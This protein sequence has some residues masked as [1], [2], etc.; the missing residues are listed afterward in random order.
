M[1][2]V[3]LLAVLLFGL[4][5]PA[6]AGPPY[7]TDDPEPTD[8]GHFEI[9]LYTGQTVELGGAAGET[10]LD[11]NYGALPDLQL[12]AV[13]PL[14]YNSPPHGETVRGLGNVELEA[15][16]RF[17][18]QETDGWDVA[19]F[20]QVVL[21]SPSHRVADGHAAY[22]LPVWAEKDFGKWSTFGG[23]GCG[24]HRGG[25]AI[26]Y[27]LVGWALTREIYP[28]LRLGAEIYHQTADVQNSKPVTGLSGGISYDLSA[29]YHLMLSAGP[30]LDNAADTDRSQWY[31][32]L[33]F[34]F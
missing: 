2:R 33:E 10:G 8:T 9:Y 26:D 22:F 21:P 17:L 5:S 19:M 14:S 16:Y 15:K 34:T 18:H 25:G 1:R 27:C 4:A 12:T 29:H 31:A 20:P 13:V 28:G 23:G 24:L 32:A 7:V 6:L 30:G 3:P 11:F